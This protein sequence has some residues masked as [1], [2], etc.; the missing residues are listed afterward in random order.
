MTRRQPS[1]IVAELTGVARAAFSSDHFRGYEHF[2]E[3][4][5]DSAAEAALATRQARY[6][7][8]VPETLTKITMNFLLCFF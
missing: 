1:K 3:I 6:H 5:R 4:S 2:R 7:R 8:T